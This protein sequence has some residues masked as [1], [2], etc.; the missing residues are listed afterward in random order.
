MRGK[1]GGP[2]RI[3]GLNGPRPSPSRPCGAP[4]N[5]KRSPATVSA[6]PVARHIHTQPGSSRGVSCLS[7]VP[8]APHPILPQPQVQEVGRADCLPSTRALCSG[9][10]VWDSPPR[11]WLRPPLASEPGQS[12]AS[13]TIKKTAGSK[14]SRR[15]RPES[16]T[17]NPDTRSSSHGHTLPGRDPQ[18]CRP[19]ITKIQPM[20]RASSSGTKTGHCR[21]KGQVVYSPK[22]VSVSRI[23]SPKVTILIPEQRRPY[24]TPS[25]NPTIPTRTSQTLGSHSN[26]LKGWLAGGQVCSPALNPG[27]PLWSLLSPG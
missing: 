7:T 21:P 20:F 13:A 2:C 12:L 27:N 19:P 15:G 23:C 22:E 11:Y 17:Y 4:Q 16:T 9:P 6:A 5:C 10:G 24:G 26:T 25:P 18:V 3:Q 1:Q 14:A 8:P